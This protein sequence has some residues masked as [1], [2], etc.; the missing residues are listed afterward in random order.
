MTYAN[1]KNGSKDLV[2]RNILKGKNF[3][4]YYDC[5]LISTSFPSHLIIFETTTEV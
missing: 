4:F 3:V 5:S 1:G 2:G